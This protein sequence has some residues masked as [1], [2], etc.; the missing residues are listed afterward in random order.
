MIQKHNC[1]KNGFERKERLLGPSKLK[2]ALLDRKNYIMS[3]TPNKLISPGLNPF[4]TVPLYKNYRQ[5][6][7]PKW[8][9][10]TCPETTAEQW[11]AYYSDTAANTEKRK[12]RLEQK[13]EVKKK[14]K[15]IAQ[16]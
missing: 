2:D 3:K 7:N 8:Q 4:K 6:I 12:R 9:D 10:I 5:H 11:E 14:L 16:M 1:I 13:F 15:S